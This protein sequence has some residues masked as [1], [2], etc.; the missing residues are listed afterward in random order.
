MSNTHPLYKSAD[1]YQAMMAWYDTALERLPFPYET[2]LISTRCG[3][4]HVLVMGAPDAPPLLMIH[5]LGGC[6][7]MWRPQMQVLAPHYRIYAIDTI[8]QPGKSTADTPSF[9]GSPYADW[10]TDT[11]DA[12]GVT[13]TAVIGLSLGGWLAVKLC[14]YAPQRVNK[15]ILISPPGLARLRPHF[16]VKIAAGVLNLRTMSD[17][18]IR[19]VT[20]DFLAPEGSGVPLHPEVE[21][22]MYLVLRHFNLGGYSVQNHSALPKIPKLVRDLWP[23]LR[24]LPAEQLRRMTTPTYLLVGQHESLF[25]PQS[26]LDYACQHLPNLCAADMIPA[27]GHALN[28]DQVDLVNT[29]LLEFLR[30]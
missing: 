18:A 1:G 11:L 10:L 12:L 8:G 5:G 16:F 30:A 3:D 20:Y 24:P 17:E 9:S 13:Q 29:M 6:A 25:N 14:L 19:Q 26:A 4:T 15:A 7:P 22:A 23:F 28:Y 2:R 27:A 21:E